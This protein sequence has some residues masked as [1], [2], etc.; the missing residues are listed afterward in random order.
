MS[1]AAAQSAA[2]AV[3]R[4]TQE[5][6]PRHVNLSIFLD[7][8]IKAMAFI[9]LTLFFIMLKCDKLPPSMPKETMYKRDGFNNVMLRLKMKCNQ[10]YMYNV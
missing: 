1:S 5:H 9:L 4:S 8:Y 7:A 10:I 3:A 6:F 2:C